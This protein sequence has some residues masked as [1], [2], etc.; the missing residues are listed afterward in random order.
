MWGIWSLTLWELSFLPIAVFTFKAKLLPLT[1]FILAF[2]NVLFL[3][4]YFLIKYN[5]IW[6]F[7][8]THYDANVYSVMFCT[9]HLMLFLGFYV[10]FYDQVTQ[11]NT[12]MTPLHIGNPKTFSPKLLL[13]DNGCSNSILK[14]MQ[15]F[16]APA[17]LSRPWSHTSHKLIFFIMLYFW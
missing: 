11:P 6:F 10:S 1:F 9:M 13:L 8:L 16:E 12:L 17:I 15:N 2:G 5:I 3:N 4:I 7:W 14:V